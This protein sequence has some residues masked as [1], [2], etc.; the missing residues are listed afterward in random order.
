LSIVRD[1]HERKLAENLIMSTLHEKEVLLAEV[2]RQTRF[3]LEVFSRILERLS[4][5]S[6]RDSLFENA[7]SA[8]NRIKSIAYI[9]ESL[10]GFPSISNIDFGELTTR[11]VRFV[12]SLYSK[13]IQNISIKNEIQSISFDLVKAIPLALIINEFLSNSLRHAFG[14]N[15]RG[16]IV[17]NV[18]NEANGKHLLRFF[19]NGIGFPDSIDFRNT[20]TLGLQLVNELTDQLSGHIE[21]NTNGG[22]EFCLEF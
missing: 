2:K 17:I 6:E 4:S 1:I 20:S 13:G 7:Q 11:L 16:K 9:K 12:F 21:L 3:D 10:Y 18:S 8:Q 5:A 22:T 19:D 15:S 14:D